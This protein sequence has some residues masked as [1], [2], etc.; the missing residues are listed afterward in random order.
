MDALTVIKALDVIEDRSPCLVSGRIVAV[1]HEFVLQIGEEALGH[2]VVIGAF[3]PA[4]A[5]ADTR[6]CKLLPILSGR[7]LRAPIGMMNQ[8]WWRL[9]LGKRHCQCALRK[10]LT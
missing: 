7:V 8:A 2:R 10:L 4:H 6:S 3:H 9:P 1:V 5:R